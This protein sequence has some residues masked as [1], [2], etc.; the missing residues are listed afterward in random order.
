MTLN[1]FRMTPKKF[2]IIMVVVITPLAVL[3][4]HNFYSGEAVSQKWVDAEL[5]EVT[6]TGVRDRLKIYLRLYAEPNGE[7]PSRQDFSRLKAKAEEVVSA[8]R[9]G[10]KTPVN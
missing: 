7:L 10:Q 8:E 6:D 3:M 1:H 9:S 4:A 5:S 2:N